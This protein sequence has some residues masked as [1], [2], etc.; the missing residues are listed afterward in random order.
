MSVSRGVEY[1]ESIEYNLL[2]MDDD[3]LHHVM[4]TSPQKDEKEIIKIFNSFKLK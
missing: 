3:M 2:L 4:L 1:H